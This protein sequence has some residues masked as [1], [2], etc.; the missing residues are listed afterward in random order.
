[1][2]QTTQ[3]YW[4]SAAG[5]LVAA[6]G[7]DAVTAA[8]RQ[9]T[10][11]GY[12]TTDQLVPGPSYGNIEVV[13]EG[14]GALVTKDYGYSGTDIGSGAG[15]DAPTSVGPT[16]VTYDDF[17]RMKTRGGGAEVFGYDLV[18]RLVTVTRTAGQSETLGYD[19][20]G[21]PAQRT[22]SG[23]TT[24]YLGRQA[25]VTSVGGLPRADVHVE[26]NGSRMAS[27]RVG[28]SPRT[29]YLHRDR[30][31]SVV[32][33]TLGGGAAGASYRYG[34]Y[35][36]LEATAGDAGDAAS[37]LGYA[38]TLRL[39]GGLLW[40]GARVYDPVTKVFLQPDPL[41][42]HSYAYAGGDPVNKW[43]PTGLAPTSRNDV[44]KKCTSP[45]GCG[46]VNIVRERTMSGWGAV[47]QFGSK[48][49]QYTVYSAA[50][51]G[52]N[53]AISIDQLAGQL[54]VDAGSLIRP[55]GSEWIVGYHHFSDI[56]SALCNLL[57]AGRT[58]GFGGAI[59]GVGATVGGGE[60]VLNYRSGGTDAFLF[61]GIQ[62]GW[63]GAASVSGYTGFVWGLNAGSSNYSGGAT[64]INAGDGLGLFAASSSG[65]L[66]GFGEKSLPDLGVV[67]AGVTVGV[68]F[69]PL[70]T[71]GTTV[72]NYSR[73]YPVGQYYG[74]SW[75]DYG[76]YFANRWC[77]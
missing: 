22:V 67:S 25:T 75:Y 59:G 64:G 68:S 63:N 8:V 9:L 1:V 3:R 23:Q 55:D 61:G 14:S 58:V 2:N 56:T 72:T 45:N 65:G 16:A 39:S 32:A 28:P 77:Q 48:E 42:P 34:A 13:K 35:G 36:A 19:P 21:L 50:E 43:D 70:P 20:F 24:W 29:L 30:L 49:Y 51:Q 69:V 11:V 54:G 73:P 27:V 40:M 6:Q 46:F 12:A 15:P 47:I 31:T 18:G 71:F 41:A 74:Y 60:L 52:A 76:L 26:V 44:P 7:Q 38:G 62:A 33:T 57:P 17:G 5:R 4:Y 53:G 37:E 10:C 66:A